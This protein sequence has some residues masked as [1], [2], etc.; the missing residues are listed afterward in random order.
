M[1]K[2]EFNRKVAELFRL[3]QAADA[4]G[5]QAKEAIAHLQ[6]AEV[7]AKEAAAAKDKA[8]DES[9]AAYR[10]LNDGVIALGLGGF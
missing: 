10:A 4:A 1:D 2:K 5:L 9:E 3:K 7:A 6:K 8:V